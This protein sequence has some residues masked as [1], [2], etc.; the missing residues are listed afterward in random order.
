MITAPSIFGKVPAMGDFVRHNAP[1]DQVDGWRAW[2]G[3]GED[4]A[5]AKKPDLP[6]AGHGAH[7]L[8]LTPPSLAG[9]S[10]LRAAEPCYFILRPRSLQF[11]SDGSYLIGV[12]A[13]SRDRV[14]RRYPLVAWQAVSAQWAE[15]L[16]A[17]PANWL[18]ELARLVH[19]HT[20]L[21]GRTSLA[22]AVE[23]LWADHR[24][25]WRDRLGVSFKRLA[26]ARNQ[27]ALG[28]LLGGSLAGPAE[29]RDDW[30][31]ILLRGGSHGSVWQ[32]GTGRAMEIDSASTIR[33]IVARL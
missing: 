2:F 9:H 20:R 29:M 33:S 21:P 19:E 32:A 15:Q 14:G 28:D 31:R 23:A 27:A 4:A 22:A 17:A 8:H 6:L 3:H 24:P 10:R 30:P 11:P 26:D 25:G 12:L 5:P 16:L 7:W 1:L 13:A 18:T